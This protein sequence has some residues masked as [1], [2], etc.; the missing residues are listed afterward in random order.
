MLSRS[1]RFG[2]LRDLVVVARPV[3]L[4]GPFFVDRFEATRADFE[5]WLASDDSSDADRLDYLDWNRTGEPELPVVGL[6]LRTARRFAR[7][8]FCRPWR[9][10]EWRWVAS[11]FG[12]HRF[13][14]GD[15]PR[16]TWA[17]SAEFGLFDFSPVGAFESGRQSAGAY[18]LV[19]N[20]GEWT[21]SPSRDW[22]ESFPIA[23][24]DAP[25]AL[26]PLLECARAF[27]REPGLSPWRGVPRPLFPLVAIDDVNLPRLV[28]RGLDA[29]MPEARRG[30]P[31]QVLDSDVELRMPRDRRWVVGVRAVADPGSLVD[32]LAAV[33]DPIDVQD[34]A[35]LRSFLRRH[36]VPPLLRDAWRRQPRGASPSGMVARILAEELGG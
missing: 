4:G 13:P 6:D 17:N 31:A 34:T 10:D 32:A 12:R 14:W 28:I 27:D 33:T 22:L 30:D 2:I 11:A 18:D 15:A 24:A 36:H 5:R 21:E 19:G 16:T 9:I 23:G 26:R 7:W 35:G 1:A 29:G 25:L 3:R 8:R 20:A